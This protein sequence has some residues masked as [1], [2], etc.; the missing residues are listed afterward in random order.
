MSDPLQRALEALSDGLPIDWD[1]LAADAP[2]EDTRQRLRALAAIASVSRVHASQR[3]RV[4][5]ETPFQWGPLQVREHVARGAHGDVYRAWDPR[6]ERQVALKLLCGDRADEE[7]LGITEGRLLA[8]VGHPNVVAI[9]GADRIEG[10]AG[11]WMEFLDG[12]TLHEEIRARGPLTERQALATILDVCS[13]LEAIHTAGLIHRDV[14]AQNVMRTRDQRTV[15]MDLGA[16]YEEHLGAPTFE[17]TPLYLAPELL[18]GGPA[19][20]SSEV[21]AVGVLLYLI[22]TG[23]YPVA[24][25]SMHDLRQNHEFRRTRRLRDRGTC[26]PGLSA[27]VDRA[28]AHN[29][30]ERFASIQDLRT[31]LGIA[32]KS[33]RSRRPSLPATVALACFAV[34]ILGL[35]SFA[36]I[37]IHS[38]IAPAAAT[39]EA[40]RVVRLPQPHTGFPS[41]DGRFYPYVDSAGNLQIFEVSLGRARRA[42]EAPAAPERLLVTLMSPDG[43][44][45]A[46]GVAVDDDAFELRIANADGTWPR[47]LLARETA[48]EP[49]P[50]DWSRDGRD[51]LCWFRQRNGTVDLALVPVV[52]HERARVL[53]SAAAAGPPANA[54]LSPDGR[55]AVTVR[56]GLAD[57]TATALIVVPTN[58]DP[59][60]ELLGTGPASRFP[61]WMPDG[62]HVFFVRDSREPANGHDGWVVAVRNGVADGEPTLVRKDIGVQ[63][64]RVPFA[65]TDN[66]E[67]SAIIAR[68]STEVY[69]A[70]LDLKAEKPVGPPRRVAETEIGRHVGPSW[71]PDGGTLAYF[72]TREP[73]VTGGAPL[74]T[75]MVHH[76][77]SRAARALRPS[78]AFLGGYA[79]RW[80]PDGRAVMVVGS[81]TGANERLG[82]Y[83]VDVATGHTTAVA[84]TP[85]SNAP[86]FSYCSSDGGHFFYLDATRGIVDRDL[87]TSNENIA[88]PNGPEL[89]PGRFAISPD[90]RSIA[91]A[92][93][94]GKGAAAMDVLRIATLGG[95]AR[96]L[97]RAPFGMLDFQAW[98]P[99]GRQIIY[100]EGRRGVSGS[101]PLFRIDTEGGQPIP[102]NL[103]TFRAPNGIAVRP[104]GRQIAYTERYTDWQIVVTPLRWPSLK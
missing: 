16:G 77:A 27:V 82:F 101:Q 39:S 97:R 9:Y 42:I 61:V 47:P 87:R 79:P 38:S 36:R 85:R 20:E 32:C 55:F 88:V 99:D 19:T 71:S 94:T 50:V 11:I 80:T 65:I 75:L 56:P 66:N 83:K 104:G 70:D 35:A 2:D 48:F 51:I 33:N 67:L 22:L 73:A 37:A 30:H 46:Y 25:V 93:K 57:S 6:L 102:L 1:A 98:T 13:G 34:L 53:Y 18:A 58:G 69:T 86:G 8:R 49:I 28:L 54:T 72:T 10:Q 26:S 14:K 95:P 100:Q 29:P 41:H 60:S 3:R 40:A 74:R 78:L 91:F 81:D 90:A 59:P 7:S 24:G 64:V 89:S 52:G 84:I 31:D 12:Q 4:T 21:Y 23:E 5:R 62:R 96:E 68:I 45:V 92:A 43:D 44:R 103:A 17:G 15:L 63:A 76:V